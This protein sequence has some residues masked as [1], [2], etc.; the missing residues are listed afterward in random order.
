MINELDAK[1][2]WLF[3]RKGKFTASEIGK[4][5]SKS[6]GTDM[7][8]TGALTYIRQ[9]AIEKMTVYWEAPELEEVKSLL[10]GKAHEYPAFEGY[11]KTTGFHSMRYFGTE[12]PVF[13]DFDENSGGSPDGLMGVGDIIH[14]GLEMKC[15]KNSN[16]HLDYL[17]M[18]DQWDLK[19]YNVDYYAQMQFL[20]MITKAP[21]WDFCS[22]DERFISPKLKTK[23][24]EVLP[25]KKFQDNL[26]IR[27]KM[28]V[29]SRDAIIERLMAA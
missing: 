29:K 3:A 22:S 12:E 10:H 19:E 11:Q 13:L 8:G 28:A 20:L 17:E 25:D 21:V 24:I 26:E 18:K 4:L 6:R 9:K 16:V 14:R 15:P 2:K 1:G 5:L 7:F 27:I 23:I